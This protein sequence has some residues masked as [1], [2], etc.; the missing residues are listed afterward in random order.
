[1]ER[2][3]KSQVKGNPFILKWNFRYYFA[4][5]DFCLFFSVL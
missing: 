2:S 4:E 3:P 5:S 1:M